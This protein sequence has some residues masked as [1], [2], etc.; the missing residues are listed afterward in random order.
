MK[1]KQYLEKNMYGK[2]KLLWVH[3]AEK[4]NFIP[5]ILQE[6]NQPTVFKMQAI[7]MK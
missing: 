3:L 1:K 7:L 2:N 5:V 6:A 4:L